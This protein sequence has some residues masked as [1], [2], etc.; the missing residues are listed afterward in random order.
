MVIILQFLLLSFYDFTILIF[1]QIMCKHVSILKTGT[2]I[3]IA[4]SLCDATLPQIVHI[5]MIVIGGWNEVLECHD[6]ITMLDLR[7]VRRY[8]TICGAR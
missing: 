2:S 5:Y 8:Q 6:R 4:L 1:F 7:N 3:K